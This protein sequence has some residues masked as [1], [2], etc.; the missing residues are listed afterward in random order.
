MSLWSCLGHGT[1][2]QFDQHTMDLHQ[3]QR[4]EVQE[5]LWY[6]GSGSHVPQGDQKDYSWMLFQ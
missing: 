2:P 6:P 1:H 4:P 3:E 5:V